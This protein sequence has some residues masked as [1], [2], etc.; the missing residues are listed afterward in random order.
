MKLNYFL[1]PLFSFFI[2]SFSSCKQGANQNTLKIDSTQIKQE[3]ELANKYVKVYETLE[4]YFKYYNFIN[5]QKIDKLNEKNNPELVKRLKKLRNKTRFV[6]KR[7]GFAKA[8]IYANIGGEYD[9]KQYAIKKPLEVARVEAYL[10]NLDKKGEGYALVKII[11]DYVD[12]L[13]K[14]FRDVSPKGFI[15]VT[16]VDSNNP[17][18]E[19][20][21]D[22]QKRDF[23]ESEFKN[24]SALL[25]LTLLSQL[26]NEVLIYETNILDNLIPN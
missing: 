23:V 19:N 13:N 18:L 24:A 11:D 21:P 3:T 4:H 7:I 17:M 16:K 20:Y 22:L 25:A 5:A 10:I 1:I 15:S 8:Y 12:Y 14:E 2:L 26:Q 6:L 9:E